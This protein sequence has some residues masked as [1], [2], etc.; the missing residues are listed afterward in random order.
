MAGRNGADGFSR[1]LSV[2][3]LILAFLAIIFGRNVVGSVFWALALALLIY[4][5][6]RIFSRNT[7]KRRQENAQYYQLRNHF[8]TKA[9]QFINRQKGRKQYHYFKCPN[10]RA[11]NRVPKGLGTLK[12]TCA[13]CKTVFE[14]KS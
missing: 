13:R 7:Y 9:R 8:T 11:F 14:R 1:F 5:Y 10:C 2:A 3:G 6:F 4:A 12:I